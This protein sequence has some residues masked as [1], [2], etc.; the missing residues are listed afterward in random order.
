MR[1]VNVRILEPYVVAR[2][3]VF[4]KTSD[5]MIFQ[6]RHCSWWPKLRYLFS[7][8]FWISFTDYRVCFLNT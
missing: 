6:H 8:W 4:F 7:F 3:F 1:F 2:F 5:D